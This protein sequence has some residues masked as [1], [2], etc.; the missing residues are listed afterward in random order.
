MTIDKTKSLERANRLHVDMLGNQ[1]MVEAV[2]QLCRMMA[3]LE[4][5]VEHYKRL[6]D[7]NLQAG[8]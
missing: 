7:A 1:P 3:E 5:E 8:R 4:Q 2:W 6:A